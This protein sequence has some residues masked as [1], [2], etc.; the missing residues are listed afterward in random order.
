MHHGDAGYDITDPELTPRQ[1]RDSPVCSQD[2]EGEK[3]FAHGYGEEEKRR[4]EESKRR[5]ERGGRGE[6]KGGQG[7]ASK[8]TEPL[9]QINCTAEHP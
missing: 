1:V 6:L 8:V 4:E 3:M 7:G 9:P 5:E 2:G